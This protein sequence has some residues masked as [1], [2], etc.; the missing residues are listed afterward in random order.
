VFLRGRLDDSVKA[1]LASYSATNPNAN[2]ATSALVKQ[3]NQLIA[4]P[5]IYDPARFSSVALRPE[6]SDL[7]KANPQ[8]IRLARLNKILLD[9]RSKGVE[10]LDFADPA[11]G[12]IGPIALQMHNAGLFDE[13]KDITVELDPKDSGLITLQ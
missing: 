3:L 4:G 6:T 13:Y 8:G 12:K 5:S 9:P 2:A 10:V 1:Y 7:F 11:A